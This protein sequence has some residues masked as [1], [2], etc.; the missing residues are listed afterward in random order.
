[1]QYGT[2]SI[3]YADIIAVNK[4]QIPRDCDPTLFLDR[5]FVRLANSKARIKPTAPLSAF[6]KK[7]SMEFP[8]DFLHYLYNYYMVCALLSH[9]YHV[10]H[11]VTVIMWHLWCDTFLHSLLCSKF[12]KKKRKRK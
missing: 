6:D 11:H 2:T 3:T 1:M 12:K 7:N 9:T 4:L 10:T 5:L 8:L